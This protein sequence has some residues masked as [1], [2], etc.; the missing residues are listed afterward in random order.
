M[1]GPNANDSVLIVEDGDAFARIVARVLERVGLT[2]HI[3]T[4]G[5]E[6]LDFLRQR[7]PLLMLLDYSLPDMTGKA[8]IENLHARK[9]N[10]PFVIMTGNGDERIAVEMM[11]LGARDYLVKDEAFLTLLPSVIMQVRDRLATER[12]LEQIRERLHERQEQLRAFARALPD[13]VFIIDEDGVLVEILSAEDGARSVSLHQQKNRQLNE[14]FPDEVA[15]LFL[16]KTR[17][18]IAQ[19]APLIMEYGLPASQGTTWFEGRT[20]PVFLEGAR[21]SMA[22]WVVRDVTERK[23]SEETLRK[24]SR[25][26]DQSPSVVVITDHR[27]HIEY[28]NPRFCEI[29]GYSAA[30]MLGKK[31]SLFRSTVQLP[32]FYQDLWRTISSGRDWRGEF[33]NRARDGSLFWER[34]VISPVKDST[35][36]ISHYLKVAEDITERKQKDET[37]H[38]LTYFD[39][40]TGLPNQM[41]LRDRLTQALA[42]AQRGGDALGV[43]IIDLDHFQRINNAFAHSFGD[44][45]L[46]QVARRLAEVMRQEDTL[47]RF[48]GDSFVMIFSH[49]GDAEDAVHVAYKICAL[50]LQP[51][52]VEGREIPL[53]ASLGLAL[54]PGDGKTP[55]TLLKHAEVALRRSK[56]SGP[57]GVSLYSPQMVQRV[58]EHLS[59]HNDMRRAI[60]RGEFAL[61]YQPQLEIFSGRVVGVEA[62]LRWNHPRLGLLEPGRFIDLAEET[63]LICPLGEWVIDEA[64]AQA[65]SW[66]DKGFPALRMAVNLSPRQ[67]MDAGCLETIAEAVHCHGI[68]PGWLTLEITESMIM[69]NTAQAI[70]LLLELKAS[71]CNIAVDDFGT[72]YSSLSYLQKF[73]F[74]I[75]KID[76]SFVLNCHE[77]SE[78]AAIIGAII[79]MAHRLG[80]RVLA[81]GV[82]RVE[83]LALL[84]ENGCD[85]VQGFYFSRPLPAPSFE[86][87]LQYGMSGSSVSHLPL[88]GK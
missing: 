48:W 64:C 76:K 31:P 75:L 80:L 67:F 84:R 2:G 79:A 33:C 22:A 53:T 41:L 34:A 40:L 8:V 72:G 56:E 20:S 11:K 45:L 13:Q 70:E 69:G 54:Y 19:R 59:L 42:H 7:T 39:P 78:S 44:K 62:L 81:E 12:S 83:H 61:F 66:A 10:I 68:E 37:I 46:Q 30:K 63:N 47:A 26:I 32:D 29:S 52:E 21:A 50:F 51:F 43:A 14:V 77:S 36:R 57:G 71:S 1:Q 9:Q 85:E 74:D 82:E 4:S 55:E 27:G 23:R 38:S 87:W 17:E 86:Y 18:A 65:R 15:A 58:S 88:V 6:A 49:L 24:L 5:R 16:Q 25:A 73:P 28:V 60:E 3:A 35:G